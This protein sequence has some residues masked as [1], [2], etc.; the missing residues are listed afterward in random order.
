MKKLIAI[1]VLFAIVAGA[2]FAELTVGGAFGAQVLVI[3]SDSS[4]AKDGKLD[5]GAFNKAAHVNADFKND[6]G[7]AGGRVRLL[8]VSDRA[9]WGAQNAFAFAWWRPIQQFRLQIGN[10]PDGD[11]GATQITGWGYNG[12]AQDYVAIDQDNGD[13]WGR[14]AARKARNQGFYPGFSSLGAIVSIYP[15]DG[16]TLNI[17]LPF[18]GNGTGDGRGNGLS[19]AGTL[20]SRFHFNGVYAIEDIGTVR[21]SFVGK[22]GIDPDIYESAGDIYVNFHTTAVE[23]LGLEVGVKF[24]LPYENDATGNTT[25]TPDVA[26]GLG[27]LFTSGDFGIKFRAGAQ[28]GGSTKTSSATTNNPTQIGV[29]ILP[30]FTVAEGLRV[31][32]NAGL[33]MSIPEEGD[34]SVE[35]FINPYLRKSISNLMFYAGVKL[36]LNDV[37]PAGGDDPIQWGIPIGFH[38]Y[39]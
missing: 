38:C 22:G 12:E 5:A 35:F 30:Y 1:A 25:V 24:G 13:D 32:F 28:L 26:V 3:G 4:D 6:N 8:S 2:A 29:G 21:L 10:N 9:W 15:L 33:G 34:A 16:L 31:Y 37:A 14:Q 23:G 27:V 36:G 18:N 17:V 19:R 39:F 7:T 20:Y 11:L